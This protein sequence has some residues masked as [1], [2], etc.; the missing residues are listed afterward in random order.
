MSILGLNPSELFNYLY[1]YDESSFLD[2]S[3]FQRSVEFKYSRYVFILTAFLLKGDKIIR[4][5]ST[6]YS[7]LYNKEINFITRFIDEHFLQKNDYFPLIDDTLTKLKTL[8]STDIAEMEKLISFID[9][10]FESEGDVF[11]LISQLAF[12][13][14]FD[15]FVIQTENMELNITNYIANY[16]FLA[17][18][19]DYLTWELITFEYIALI[20]RK[21]LIETDIIDIEFNEELESLFF[22]LISPYNICPC[23][24]TI[25][26]LY[27][28]KIDSF[29]EL[30][31]DSHFRIIKSIIEKLMS[32]VS[33][34][35]TKMSP[36]LAELSFAIV[37][38]RV[39][40]SSS[41][42]FQ[43]ELGHKL[44]QLKSLVISRIENPLLVPPYLDR[45]ILNSFSS[46]EELW[47]EISRNE[48]FF[49]SI[50][51]TIP[52]FELSMSIISLK[53]NNLNLKKKTLI[54]IL[55]FSLS[56]C[57]SSNGVV[58]KNALNILRSICKS[59]QGFL[60]DIVNYMLFS[61]S[62][63]SYL[64]NPSLNYFL[65][66]MNIILNKIKDLTISNGVI[67]SMLN[68][69]RLSTSL[70]ISDS[71]IFK[72]LE[73]FPNL[74]NN[75]NIDNCDKMANQTDF[76][77][78]D[79]IHNNQCCLLSHLF[80]CTPNLIVVIL[81]S[82]KVELDY[83]FP[84][85]NS[86]SSAVSNIQNKLNEFQPINSSI[87][88]QNNKSYSYN[89][90]IGDLCPLNQLNIKRYVNFLIETNNLDN[91]IIVILDFLSEWLRL[92]KV[93]IYIELMENRYFF[94][95]QNTILRTEITDNYQFIFLLY[96]FSRTIDYEKLNLILIRIKLQ[97]IPWRGFLRWIDSWRQKNYKSVLNGRIWKILF[98]EIMAILIPESFFVPLV[99]IFHKK[100]EN[101]KS[102]ITSKCI[103]DKINK[104][105]LKRKYLINSCEETLSI[106][107]STLYWLELFYMEPNMTFYSS[108]E[109]LFTVPTDSS[110]NGFLNLLSEFYKDE[111]KFKDLLISPENYFNSNIR[112]FF[113][114]N[115]VEILCNIYLMMLNLYQI[116]KD[117]NL[118]TK[119]FINMDYE[120]FCI[121]WNKIIY[122]TNFKNKLTIKQLSLFVE[123][124]LGKN[125]V[126]R[127][128]I[129]N[130]IKYGY[131][132]S[133]NSL[134]KFLDKIQLLAKLICQNNVQ[135]A[136]EQFVPPKIANNLDK[137]LNTKTLTE[138]W[139][140]YSVTKRVGI[141]GYEIEKQIIHCVLLLLLLSNIVVET[142]NTI[143]DPIK[144]PSNVNVTSLPVVE[145]TIV[146]VFSIAQEII[147]LKNKGEIHEN[148]IENFTLFLES[149]LDFVTSI[150]KSFP[151][152]NTSLLETLD[153]LKQLIIDKRLTSSKLITVLSSIE[154]SIIS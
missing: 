104:W 12:R 153:A 125:D 62:N 142:H 60:E 84:F 91:I 89:E 122:L 116:I 90:T 10:N 69:V 45:F 121:V 145:R 94:I 44:L 123:T 97:N 80:W 59:S 135:I 30:K 75:C 71:T 25:L 21:K 74:V 55:I 147:K 14:Y 33:N 6:S 36:D 105:F 56:N 18:S 140:K 4:K 88:P 76:I 37:Y 120:V 23:T 38:I 111:N 119:C 35:L 138:L 100:Y 96:L 63:C 150:S 49:Q 61:F 2:Q 48:L 9:L 127:N 151:Q 136:K 68:L 113:G 5:L 148:I 13:F 26:L 31:K 19:I 133:K 58:N 131:G 28:D 118:I 152:I 70:E 40:A 109:L 82:I 8:G 149:S 108:I 117:Q 124:I 66:I 146:R 102:L 112:Y 17:Y 137:L 39:L 134:N 11:N 42:Q 98:S 65:R 32:F 64:M 51:I 79:L 43:A 129:E 87:R 3:W 139:G 126:A 73:S 107:E 99:P 78:M 83:I 34:T 114:E 86:L 50:L 20:K 47:M 53:T 22:L 144:G 141:S 77:L 106:N 1:L 57:L 101:A 110:E 46:F 7:P 24:L 132:E 92:N 103:R 16:L 85:V 52:S 154:K 128:L 54:F 115:S 15:D 95:I 27:K 143:S 81:K 93:T 130:G 67:I 41:F 29:N 72:F